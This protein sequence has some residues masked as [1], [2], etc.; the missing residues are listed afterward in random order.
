MQVL[1]WLGRRWTLRVLWELRDGALPFRA[2]Q[3]RCDAVSPTVLNDRLR[4]LRDAGVVD[5]A[6]GGGYAL[7][8]DGAALGALLLPLHRWAEGWARRARTRRA[9]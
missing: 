6:A 3:E 9:H 7:T 5:L 1:D 4:E 2:L 8:A